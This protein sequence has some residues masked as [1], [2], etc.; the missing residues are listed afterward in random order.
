MDAFLLQY[1]PGYLSEIS[2]LKIWR[3]KLRG[4]LR[5]LFHPFRITQ[6]ITLSALSFLW[7]AETPSRENNFSRFQT[8]NVWKLCKVIFN[9][10]VF[11]TAR[12]QQKEGHLAGRKMFGQAR[13]EINWDFIFKGKG[14]SAVQIFDQRDPGIDVWMRF[15]FTMVSQFPHGRQVPRQN[16]SI[17]HL[18]W[19]LSTNILPFSF[20]PDWIWHV[21]Q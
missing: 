15:L 14:F 2:G 9:K 7:S 5:A 4:L 3:T 17:Q 20:L 16:L 10:G 1:I 6:T 12:W 13:D 11:P 21:D 18:A 8:L 19:T